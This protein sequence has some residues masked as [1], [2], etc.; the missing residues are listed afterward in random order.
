MALLVPVVLP[1]PY[2]QNTANTPIDPGFVASDS[3]GGDL[4]PITGREIVIVNNTDVGAQTITVTSQPGPTT[5]RTGD[6]TAAPIPIGAIRAFQLFPWP[7]WIDGNA[8]MAVQTSTNNVPIA[9]LRL[10]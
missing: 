4:I 10:R 7:G 6:I 5:Q 8:Q 3:A 2:E 1:T 9:I